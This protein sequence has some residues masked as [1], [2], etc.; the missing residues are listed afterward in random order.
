MPANYYGSRPNSSCV[1]HVAT[2]QLLTS[3]PLRFLR[4][5]TLF[6]RGPREMS[7]KVRRVLVATLMIAWLRVPGLAQPPA[8]GD[9][10]A[11]RD[12]TPR[13]SSPWLDLAPSEVLAKH[14][15]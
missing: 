8:S 3:R 11:D 7:P 10:P 15:Q 9:A 13:A 5:R 4:V 1:T 2:W 12:V 14:A 6:S